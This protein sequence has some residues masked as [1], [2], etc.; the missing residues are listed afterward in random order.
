M[1]QWISGIGQ[2]L[3]DL[4]VT[5]GPLITS[6]SVAFVNSAMGN[7]TY[8]G[9][10][11]DTPFA[12]LAHAITSESGTAGIIVL[13]SGHTET[14]TGTITPPAGTIIVGA[15]SSG[16]KPTVKLKLN[17]AATAMVTC[18]NAG[19]QLRNIWF[20][21]SQQTNATSKV[22]FTGINGLVSGCYFECGATDTGANIELGTGS[23]GTRVENTT[24][25]S[26]ATTVTA[27]PQYGLNASAALTDIDIIGCVFSGGTSGFSSWALNLSSVVTRQRVEGLSL[28]L[29]ADAI[30]GS[31]TGIVMPTTVTGSSRISY[32]GGV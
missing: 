6:Y 30:F 29:G 16:G 15:G 2:N 27:Q 1:P 9:T 32:S 14:L 10:D 4:L 19:V 20:Q 26:T 25:I 21:A 18:S 5:Q 28:L 22:K 12:T 3:G 11:V 8:D 13:M 24:I 17:A 31:S 7:D 23:S